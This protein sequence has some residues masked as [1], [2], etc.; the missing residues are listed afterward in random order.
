[1][2]VTFNPGDLIRVKGRDEELAVYTVT[3]GRTPYICVIADGK[4]Q[5][6]RPDDV[7]EHRPADPIAWQVGDR[8]ALRSGDGRVVRH[9]TL[10]EWHEREQHWFLRV[11]AEPHPTAGHQM[12]GFETWLR[13]VDIVPVE[14]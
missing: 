13:G 6:F 10:L 1:M 2:R 12:D 9:G 7:T 3:R 14:A 5:W 11:D 4:Q 8:F